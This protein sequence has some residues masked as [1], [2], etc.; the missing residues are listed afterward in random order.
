[1]QVKFNITGSNT[2]HVLSLIR[3]AGV[4]G[5]SPTVERE[6][7]AFK[8]HSDEDKLPIAMFLSSFFS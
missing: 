2:G 6:K 3:P 7:N 4:S 5:V 8:E 1:M